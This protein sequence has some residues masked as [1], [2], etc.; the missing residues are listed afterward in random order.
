MSKAKLTTGVNS[1]D[2]EVPIYKV[3]FQDKTT[4]LLKSVIEKLSIDR[5]ENV[6]FRLP[7]I[8]L[9][10]GE[11]KELLAKAFANSICFKFEHVQSRH[12]MAGGSCGSLY[13]NIDQET[14]YYI[15]A[16]E[17]LT[18]YS[19]SMLFK[20][21]TEGYSK[22]RIYGGNYETVTAENKLFIFSTDH[23]EQICPDLYKAIDYHCVLN[24]YTTEQMEIIVEQRLKWCGVGFEEQIPAIIVRNGEGSMSKCIRLLSIC[25]LV[26]RGDGRTKM[27]MGDVEKGIGL[28]SQ[29]GVPAPQIDKEI[30][31]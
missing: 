2:N 29:Q 25:F 20:L 15:S 26:M 1:F 7:G 27:I 17:E 9:S 31:F 22:V 3:L 8:L 11:G 6:N 10:D 23:E 5:F 4:L 21:L 12:L 30:S 16:A 28:N 13:K 18:A 24:S 14:V 19:I